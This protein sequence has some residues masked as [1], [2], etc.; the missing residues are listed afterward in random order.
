[1]VFM[2]LTIA[3][4][5]ATT[6]PNTCNF[7]QVL[8]LGKEQC[9]VTWEPAANVPSAVVDEFEKGILITVSDDVSSTGIGQETHTLAAMPSVNMA[10][11]SPSTPARR[12]VIGN[13][14]G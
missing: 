13:N 12:P 14:D 6:Y 2:A 8:W 10:S 5:S 3:N 11:P 7:K 1:M 4:F 9:A